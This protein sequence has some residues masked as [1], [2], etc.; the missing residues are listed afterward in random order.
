MGGLD[1]VSRAR[2]HYTFDTFG[3]MISP[4]FTPNWF[5]WLFWV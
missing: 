5:G 4:T 1:G 2:V 3:E